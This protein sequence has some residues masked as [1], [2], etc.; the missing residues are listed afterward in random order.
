MNIYVDLTNQFNDGY[1]RAILSSGQAVVL[2]RLA[3]MSK[4]GD[5]IVR[6]DE[7]SLEYILM[8][9][10][11]KCARYRFGA[12]LDKRWLAG[13]WSSHFE[14][15]KE[16]IRIRT[17]FVSKPPRIDFARLAQI[18]VEQENRKLPFVDCKDLAQLKKTNRE[19]DYAVIGELSRK[20][21]TEADTL[22]YSRS[23]R[24]I[25][26]IFLQNPALVS[27]ILAER[28]IEPNACVNVETLEIALDAERRRL[29]HANERRLERY[30]LA[31]EGWAEIW[32]NVEKETIG[33]SLLEAHKKITARAEGVLPFTIPAGD[34]HD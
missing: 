14:F 28:G 5:W 6:E 8:V 34:S 26:S 33:L 13:G 9:L 29:M 20:M 15:I 22:R 10:D 25:I 12:P 1:L 17:D 27:Q 18:W 31:V 30:A 4:D 23:A 24:D 2:H 21:E 16:K 11:R 7:K 32:K 3:I 19:K